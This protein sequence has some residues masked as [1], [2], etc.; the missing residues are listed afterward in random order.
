MAA[1]YK[2]LI[3]LSSLSEASLAQ[4]LTLLREI[5]LPAGQ[6]L[7]RRGDQDD[8]SYYL[9]HG[10]L[11]L[12]T[13]DGSP[14]RRVQA[15][16]DAALHPLARLKP[17]VYTGVARSECR[18]ACFPESALDNLVAMDQATA[19]EVTEIEGDDPQWMFELMCNHAFARIPPTN[20]HEL[21]ARFEA[22]PVCAGQ[23][24]IRQGEAGD[25]Y[26]LIREGQA[27]VSRAMPGNAPVVLA[28]IQAGEGFGEE[29]LI[30]GDARNATVTML[31]D[32]LLMR[33]SAQDFND[34]L[35][36]PLVHQ[37]S[38]AEAVALVRDQG[39][40]LLDVRLE[41]EFKQGSLKG[42]INIPLFLLRIKAD[43]LRRNRVYICFCQSGQRSNTA[44]FLLARQGF[45]VRVLQGGLA[46]LARPPG[47]PGST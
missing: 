26:Y 13:E 8:T 47:E 10:E 3:P 32:G 21:F 15:G 43:N 30:S 29:A 23:V 14:P 27:Q 35:K 38:G 20:L 9:M 44:A 1:T 4:A 41:E 25:F 36:A 45:D 11:S 24:V 22:V 16:S 39:A 17:R 40:K 37:V 42:A 31:S 5:T 18:L 28:R 12:D 33:L 46:A 2:D 7:F 19:Y 6:T 34:Q